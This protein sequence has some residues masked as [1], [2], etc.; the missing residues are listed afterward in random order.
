MDGSAALPGSADE[1]F[2]ADWYA[3]TYPQV[4]DDIRRGL[5]RD[6][7]EHFERYGRFR[8]YLPNPGATRSRNPAGVRSAFGGLWTDQGNAL[9]L[10]EG[11]LELGL[12]DAK[13]A[14]ALRA[15]IRDGYVVFRN[16]ISP[17]ALRRARRALDDAYDGK[18]AG[19]QFNCPELGVEVGPWDARMKALP[20]KALEIHARSPAIRDAVFAPV[21]SRFLALIFERRALATQSLGFYRGSGQNGHQ[22]S[23]YVTYTL[24]LQFAASWIALEDVQEGAGE[25]FYR[26]GSQNLGDFLY[27][28]EFKSVREAQRLRPDWD[29]G[30]MDAHVISLRERSDQVG[31]PEKTFL[32]KAGDVLIWASDLVHGGKPISLDRTRKSVV[33][34]Y[35]P[36][37]VAPLYVE[38]GARR[39]VRRHKSGNSWTT[40]L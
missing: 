24:P 37:D 29:A 13:L 34:H 23:A 36:K 8:G 30:E 7:A 14:Q 32:A 1:A 31:Y 19:Q 11:K 20:A 16:A 25:L 40:F 6:A 21:I 12:I 27:A 38:E 28:G 15:Y 9:D 39:K 4:R 35:C 18:I 5:A 22:D 2:R 17:W 26:V 33:T 10:V 3:N